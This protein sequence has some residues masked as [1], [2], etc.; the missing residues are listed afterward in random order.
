MDED[1]GVVF[2]KEKKWQKKIRRK[3]PN[4]KKIVVISDRGSI[5]ILEVLYTFIMLDSI[6]IILS[7]HFSLS[8]FHLIVIINSISISINK[9]T[10]FVKQTSRDDHESIE[11][12]SSLIQSFCNKICWETFFKSIHILKGIM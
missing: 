7:P 9:Y 12:A 6:I 1:T 8:L 11:P 5:T 10:W 3:A 4:N 2:N